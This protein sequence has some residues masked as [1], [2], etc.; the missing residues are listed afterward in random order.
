MRRLLLIAFTFCSL[1]LFAC[2]D[3]PIFTEMATNRL[4]VVLKG[5]Y[6]SND[7]ADWQSVFSKDDSVDDNDT[8]VEFD[9]TEFMMDIAEMRLKASGDSDKF[10]FY[11]QTYSFLISDL[12]DYFN[13][14]GVEFDCDDPYSGRNYIK[15]Y[16]YIRKM[17]FNN[18]ADY[19]LDYSTGNWIT[20]DVPEVI[21]REEDVYGF[22]INQ[23]QY[24]TYWDTLRIEGEDSI[25]IFPLV[26]E[27]PGGMVFDREDPETVLEVRFV[28]KNFLKRFELDYYSD[29][30]YHVRHFWGLSDWLRDVSP[31]ETV[32]GGNVLA[33]ARAY[34]PGKTATI[35]GDIGQLRVT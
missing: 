10:A 27:I 18:A 8:A 13:G 32:M 26:V 14:T 29:G 33:V 15:L 30:Y 1:A 3:Y 19:R 31:D 35:T 9:P 24:T 7:P 16:V 21:F 6:E 2:G 23:V 4:K 22:D 12:E 28:I 20:Q 34:V 11:R 25:Y 17:I 5:T